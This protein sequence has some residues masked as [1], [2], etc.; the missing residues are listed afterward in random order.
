MDQ[1]TSPTGDTNLGHNIRNSPSTAVR[2]MIC[3]ITRI[4]I[5][6]TIT[7]TEVPPYQQCFPFIS[8]YGRR[9]V[10]VSFLETSNF[11]SGRNTEYRLPNPSMLRRL[12]RRL[13][14]L[15]FLYLKNFFPQY[16]FVCSR[17]HL[18]RR[19]RE[20]SHI[21]F[22]SW[23]GTRTTIPW[24]FWG[25]SLARNYFHTQQHQR[26]PRNGAPTT[27]VHPSTENWSAQGSIR[28]VS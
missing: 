24:F 26:N 12:K 6:L 13:Q 7:D 10:Y 21:W 27:L 1:D 17:K 18:R 11:Y 16:S 5:A 22:Q 25:N 8:Q 9:N 28:R 3:V 23:Y 4:V 19:F 20:V 2:I 14:I 15:M